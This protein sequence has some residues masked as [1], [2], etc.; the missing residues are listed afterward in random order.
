[1]PDIFSKR[2]AYWSILD[3]S[4]NEL[5]DDDGT[6][7]ELELIGTQSHEV[8]NKADSCHCDN[9]KRKSKYV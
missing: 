7:P 6:T 2:M 1:M 9:C 5:R 4:L 3:R 8:S